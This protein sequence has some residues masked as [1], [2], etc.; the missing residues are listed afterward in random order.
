[1]VF[2]CKSV[3]FRVHVSLQGGNRR[4]SKG[5]WLRNTGSNSSIC[6]TFFHGRGAARVL[7]GGSLAGMAEEW[8]ITSRRMRT[9]GRFPALQRGRGPFSNRVAFFWMSVFHSCLTLS[10]K[11]IDHV[12]S[13]NR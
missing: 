3:F 5:R 10:D 1:M 6:S 9:G 8:T 11:K 12:S 13:Q 2:V 7:F 4:T